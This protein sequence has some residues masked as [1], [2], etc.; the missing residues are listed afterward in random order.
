MDMKIS[1]YSRNHHIGIRNHFESKID[2][3]NMHKLFK[4]TCKLTNSGHK[5]K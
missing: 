2:A 4:C 5:G 1:T 3:H